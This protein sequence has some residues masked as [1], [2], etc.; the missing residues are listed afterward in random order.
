MMLRRVLLDF[1]SSRI[2]WG[3]N[4]HGPSKFFN[5]AKTLFENRDAIESHSFGGR[6]KAKIFSGLGDPKPNLS[7]PKQPWSS[8]FLFQILLVLWLDSKG[9]S[10]PES[11]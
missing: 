10:L 9:Q 3:M 4:H 5:V 2:S 7:P 11:S 1:D 6:T 8:T